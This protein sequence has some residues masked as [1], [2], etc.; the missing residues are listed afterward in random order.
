MVQWIAMLAKLNQ[1]FEVAIQAMAIGERGQA[2]D[3]LERCVAEKVDNA[4]F[5]AA[6]PPFRALRGELRFERLLDEL[7]LGGSC[8]PTFNPQPAASP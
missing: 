5:I 3:A 8:H 6:F 4:P 1:W 2:L 7:G